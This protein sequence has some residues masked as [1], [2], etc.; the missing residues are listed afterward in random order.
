MK[1]LLFRC[2]QV[3]LTDLVRVS[4]YNSLG[5]LLKMFSGLISIKIV[6]SVVGPTGMALLG[7][8]T[9]FV[10]I[11]QSIAGG[12]I[13]TGLT[14]YIS[15][16][17]Q[18]ENKA[19]IYIGTAVRITVFLSVATGILLNAFASY[20]SVSLFNTTDYAYVFRVFGVTI[21]FYVANSVLMAIL[22]G[23]KKFKY[24]VQINIAGSLI[25]LIFSVVLV[26]IW[27]LKGVMISV[28]TYQSVLFVVAILMLIR[29]NWTFKLFL[30]GVY[31]KFAASNLF[32][33]SLMALSTA[34]IIPLSQ[35][36]VRGFIVDHISSTEAGMW[37][38]INRI[39]GM[40]LQ[41]V[42]SSLGVYYLPRIAELK[43]E[44]DLQKEVMHV[45]KIIIPLVLLSIIFIYSFREFI[46]EIVFTNKF[47]PMESLFSFQLL[48]DLLKISGWILGYIMVARA[49]VG[50][51][52]IT[53]LFNYGSFVILSILLVKWMGVKGAVIA[54]ATCHALY[55]IIMIIVFRRLLFRSL[56]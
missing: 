48:G 4:F 31:T 13:T 30:S 3:L 11:I 52:I 29:Q 40:Y 35:L 53:E 39:S 18:D 2:K 24:F 38:G 33:Y 51:Y 41:V 50:T 26:L 7:Q 47:T 9:N 54:Y 32:H 37:E 5:T 1:D 6:A 42:V 16:N 17:Q 19:S 25:S 20:F 12:G 23:Y 14:R 8:L 46:I 28:V 45:F 55:L 15:E 43:V 56:N 34:L 22:N 10:T 44:N 27:G 36:L 49:M 21:I